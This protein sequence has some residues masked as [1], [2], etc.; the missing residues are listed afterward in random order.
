MFLGVL[1][2]VK[3]VESCAEAEHVDKIQTKVLKEFSSFLFTV[4][5]T[6]YSLQLC[7]EISISSN[8]PDL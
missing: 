5:S 2:S 6:L 7:L 4:T 1:A 3:I 8:S